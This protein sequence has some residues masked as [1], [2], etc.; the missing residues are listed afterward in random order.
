MFALGAE[1]SLGELRRLGR[2]TAAGGPLQIVL[3][4]GLGPLLAPV[5]GL[6]PLQGVFL[7]GLLAL[8]SHRRSIG[9]K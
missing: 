7:G 8:S 4:M 2:V 1:V 9:R 3:T 6:S 5:L